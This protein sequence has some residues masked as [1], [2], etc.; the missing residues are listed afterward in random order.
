MIPM[1]KEYEFPQLE[2]LRFDVKDTVMDSDCV[3]YTG[4]VCPYDGVC[5]LDINPDIGLSDL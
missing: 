2:V 4:G 5:S 1:K 3:T